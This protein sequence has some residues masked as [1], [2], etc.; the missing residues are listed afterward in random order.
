MPNL[1]CQAVLF[2]P[3]LYRARTKWSTEAN[4]HCQDSWGKVPDVNFG[5]SREKKLYHLRYFSNCLALVLNTNATEGTTL[6]MTCKFLE[7]TNLQSVY[8]NIGV[9]VEEKTLNRCIF[10][11][12]L[13]L[14]PISVLNGMVSRPNLPAACL[15]ANALEIEGG[16]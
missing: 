9:T 16:V 13:F 5:Q 6:E 12:K 14:Y 4:Q 8:H 11:T 1:R 2:W 3:L 10:L 7:G 15:S